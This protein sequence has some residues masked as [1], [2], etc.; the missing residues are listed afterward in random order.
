MLIVSLAG[1]ALVWA[2][3]SKLSLPGDVINVSFNLAQEPEVK[4]LFESDKATYY[5]GKFTD[6]QVTCYVN[7]ANQGLACAK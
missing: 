5:F 2:K 1:L 4:A 3:P 7:L 6:G